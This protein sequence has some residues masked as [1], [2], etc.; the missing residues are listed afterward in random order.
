MLN[1]ALPPCGTLTP[2]PTG[3]LPTATRTPTVTP[4]FCMGNYVFATA[5]ATIVPG[6]NDI[7]NH[8]DDCTSTIA[9]PFPINYYGQLFNTADVSSN[10]N[11]QFTTFNPISFNQCLPRRKSTPPCCRTSMTCGPTRIRAARQAGAECSPR[12]RA[13]R[14]TA[15]SI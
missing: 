13:A 7:G 3:T 14:L 11:I 4:T 8:C 10:G 15:F 1:F 5:T 9:F 12:Y 2:T 6:N